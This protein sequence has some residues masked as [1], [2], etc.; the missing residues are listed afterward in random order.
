MLLHH[1]FLHHD[2]QN[3]ISSSLLL[4]LLVSIAPFYIA[5]S[6]KQYIVGEDAYHLQ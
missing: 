1:G 6:L 3:I 4:G 2:V 5:V